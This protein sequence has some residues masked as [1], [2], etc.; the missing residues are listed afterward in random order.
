MSKN[1]L[2]SACI[3]FCLCAVAPAAEYR[4]A[5]VTVASD[6]DSGYIQVLSANAEAFS[7]GLSSGYFRGAR[8]GQVKICYAKDESEARLLVAEDGGAKEAGEGWYVPSGSTLYGWAEGCGDENGWGGLFDGITTHF[9]RQSAPA[10][11]LW[12]AAGL[13]SFFGDQGRIEKG[14]LVIAHP[15]VGGAA[16]TKLM[17]D[18]KGG[19]TVT[20]LAATTDRQF[21]SWEAGAGYAQMLFYWLYENGL[22]ER[23]ITATRG[24]GYDAAVLEEVAG[25]PAVKINSELRE[26]RESVL[27]AVELAGK[28]LAC[29]DPNEKKKYFSD[30]LELRPNYQA[31]RLELAKCFYKENNPEKCRGLLAEIMGASEPVEYRQAAQWMGTS[32]YGQKDYGKAIEYY[33]SAWETSVEYECR[34]RLA[35]Q[36]A[37]C[38]YH[39]EDETNAV[40]WYQ[41]FLEGR[42]DAEDCRQQADFARQYLD[43][44]VERA[45][46]GGNGNTF[47]GN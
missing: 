32:F 41:K 35:Y 13:C 24:R 21:G 43:E 22:L 7:K 14:R 16:F 26:F 39:L 25:R 6:L 34:Y 1:I 20:R 12:F 33:T 37:T 38:Y 40:Q 18:E 23:Y 47:P 42:W 30:A 4:G 15:A 11:P 45:P 2:L 17:K 3:V 29:E 19:L 46:V 44:N 28:G 5:Y 27:S 31:A 8:V 10:A 9:V 36:I